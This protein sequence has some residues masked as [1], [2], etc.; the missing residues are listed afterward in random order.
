MTQ[1]LNK[2]VCLGLSLIIWVEKYPSCIN[3]LRNPYSKIVFPF[4][5]S[6][7]AL[8]FC[9]KLICLLFLIFYL[10]NMSFGYF[11]HHH[12]FKFFKIKFISLTIL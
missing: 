2:K 9:N 11:C 4:F 6:W 12:S 5:E 3:M 8:K 7:F 10:L 1:V